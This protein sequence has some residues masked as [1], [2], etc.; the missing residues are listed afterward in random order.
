MIH[1][2]YG[3]Q[4]QEL[5]ALVVKGSGPNLLGRD[6][7]EVIRLDWNTI[8]QI[9][10]NSPQAAL[11]DVLAKYPDVFAEGLGTLKGVKAKIY[12]DQDAIRNILKPDRCPT[13]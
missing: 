13:H 1:V 9:A 10:S 6:W 2:K 7:L 11:Q 4:Q 12:V 8:F 3:N 5:E